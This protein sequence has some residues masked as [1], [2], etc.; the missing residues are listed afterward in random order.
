M[1]FYSN[2]QPLQGDFDVETMGVLLQAFV[3]QPIQPETAHTSL[4]LHI[5][6][7]FQEAR[8]KK[9]AKWKHKVVQDCTVVP[10]LL[11]V[12]SEI[13]EVGAGLVADVRL[14]RTS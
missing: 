3:A 12:M 4:P 10:D 14:K 5:D 9:R 2:D 11:R 1:K 7:A 13:K 8:P 6:N